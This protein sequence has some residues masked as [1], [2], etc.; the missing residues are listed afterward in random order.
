MEKSE[1]QLFVE[2]N[3][4]N[5]LQEFLTKKLGQGITSL[6]DYQKTLIYDYTKNGHETLNDQLLSGKVDERHSYYC[7]FLNEALDDLFDL[8][9]IVFRGVNLSENQIDRYRTAKENNDIIVEPAFTSTSTS[10]LVAEGYS[11][12]KVIF[13][14]ISLH[15]KLIED[16]SY[17][18]STNPASNEKEVLFKS[19]TKFK[20]LN[21]ETKE[22]GSTLIILKEVE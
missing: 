19:E 2:S 20:V 16:I 7:G 3:F 18:G 12:G 6:D 9:G 13:E 15:G 8:E 14:I 17:Y 4:N 5:Q 10:N 21:I 11:K 22:N 1:V